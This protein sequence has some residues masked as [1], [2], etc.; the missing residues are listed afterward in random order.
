MTK[1]KKMAMVCMIAAVYAAVSLVLAPISYG[2][3]QCRVAE[4][5]N[6]VPILMPMSG[7]GVIL[8]CFLTN[9]IGVI[10]GLNP[11]GMMDCLVGTFA[12]A[13][14]VY[15]VV[16]CK[17]IRFKGIPWLSMLM[18][19]IANGIIIGIELGVVFFQDNLLIGTLISGLEV[20]IGELVAMVLG[21]FLIKALEKTEI[22]K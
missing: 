14:A 22:F 5:L 7:W 1:T 15:G 21:L 3:I 6:L 4:A 11:L 18:P 19:V 17:D 2:N 9:F 20:A 13:V 8:G 12:T 10:N 16:K